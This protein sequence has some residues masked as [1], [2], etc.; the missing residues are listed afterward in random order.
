MIGCKAAVVGCINS[1]MTRLGVVA[2]IHIH[3]II[4]Q[5]SLC[6]KVMRLESVVVPTI[7]FIRSHGLNYRQFQQFLSETEAEYGDVL[8][9]T[10]VR[11]LS[12]G[13]VSRRFFELR[14]E[15]AVFLRGKGKPLKELAD[16][17]WV[18]ELALP[19][20][21]SQHLNDLNVK[22]Q[23]KGKLVSGI[24]ADVRAFEM[25][26]SLFQ[27]QARKSNFYHFPCCKIFAGETAT[28]F[29]TERL[30][31]ILRELKREFEVRFADFTKHWSDICLFQ[32]PFNAALSQVRDR[33]QIE[34]A[35][36]PTDNDLKSAFAA[37]DLVTF[38]A[39]LADSTF[40]NL[41]KPAATMITVFG[42]PYVCEQTFSRMK[43]IKSNLRSRM[44]DENL[45]NVLR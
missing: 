32:N 6:S 21:V 5:Q 43:C 39:G 37:N 23:G 41:K 4:H 22:L 33:Y 17:D 38:Y 25:K 24:L 45:H 28:P 20:D 3:C 18:W 35:D 13:R 44:T 11:W 27:N 8:Y 26:L 10:E 19:A 14:E 30:C 1:E 29:P 15:I 34:L 40:M 7:N 42:S 16:H 31:E 12:R 2:P 36:L 9:H